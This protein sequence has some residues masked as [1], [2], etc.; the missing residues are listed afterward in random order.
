MYVYLL[1]HGQAT[2]TA[3]LD[4]QRTLSPLGIENI[5]YLAKA[6]V[7]GGYKIDCCF[8]SPYLRAQQTAELFLKETDLAVAIETN[9][10]L[11]PDNNP[12]TAIG[13]LQEIEDGNKE[14]NI[15]LVGHNPYLSELYTILTQARNTYAAK[16]LAPGE[17]CGINFDFIGLGLGKDVLNI[18]PAKN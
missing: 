5:K 13:L 6:F 12:L 15:L 16:I 11:K 7:A 17:L 2:H 4:S 10:I 14:S 3:G 9:G 8:A 18:S 1:R